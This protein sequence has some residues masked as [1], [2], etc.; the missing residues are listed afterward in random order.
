MPYEEIDHT[1][2]WAFRVRAPSREDLFREAAEALY[3]LGGIETRTGGGERSIH[4]QADDA[5]GLFILWLNELLFLLE[6]EQ[7]ALRDVRIERL[8]GT[9]LGASGRAAEVTAVGKYI[10][11]AT[12]SGFRILEED[13]FWRAEVVL[14]V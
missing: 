14:D 11:A 10:K 9:E 1:A 4:L 8:T 5:E 3:A 13:G 12:Y 6:E 2:D 7:I